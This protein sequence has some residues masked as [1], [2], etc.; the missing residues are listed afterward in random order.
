MAKPTVNDWAKLDRL[1]KYLVRKPRA[2]T[3]YPWQDE[4]KEIITYTDS[5]WAGCR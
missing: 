4:L 5:D 3:R 1:A 2:V